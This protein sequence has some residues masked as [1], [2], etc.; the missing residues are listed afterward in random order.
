MLLICFYAKIVKESA[1]RAW[2]RRQSIWYI[3]STQCL[4]QY[5]LNKIYYTTVLAVLSP[6]IFPVPSAEISSSM[7]AITATSKP[8][9]ST[10]KKCLLACCPS[11]TG[12]CGIIAMMDWIHL[13]S[14]NMSTESPWYSQDHNVLMDS[15]RS[16]RHGFEY[17]ETS[18]RGN[19]CPW[20]QNS[21]KKYTS[22]IRISS[23][24]SI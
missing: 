13:T 20:A 23:L 15:L 11:T 6:L 12:A 21:M 5:T 18:A 7:P 4:W 9:F 10:R 8:G 19:S 17:R 14:I 3:V 1:A 24:T 2:T 22:A 16:V